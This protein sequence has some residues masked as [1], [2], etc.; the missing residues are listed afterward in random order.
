M[1][2]RG[3]LWLNHHELE[4][5]PYFKIRDALLG[6]GKLFDS[7]GINKEDIPAVQQFQRRIERADYEKS[8]LQKTTAQC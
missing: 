4:K 5:K 1:H 6:E 7:W 3:T 2:R 8:T